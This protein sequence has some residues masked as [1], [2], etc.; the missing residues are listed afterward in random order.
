MAWCLVKN[1]YNFTLPLQIYIEINQVGLNDS[2]KVGRTNR[3]VNFVNRNP[4]KKLSSET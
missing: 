1:R 3:Q 2:G 4:N